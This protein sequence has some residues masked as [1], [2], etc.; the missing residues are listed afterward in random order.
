MHYS[1]KLSFIAKNKIFHISVLIVVE[2]VY[3]V[4]QHVANNGIDDVPVDIEND[5]AFGTQ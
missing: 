5:L 3:K 4:K 2:F 1:I